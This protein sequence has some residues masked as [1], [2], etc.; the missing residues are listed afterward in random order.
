MT[1]YR[2]EW[3]SGDLCPGGNVQASSTITDGSTSYT[4][5]NLSPG[6][7]CNVSVTASN[8]AGS[9]SSD[10]VTFLLPE[11]GEHTPAETETAL[12][13]SVYCLPLPCIKPCI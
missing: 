10:R 11:S 6:T 12:G 8:S 2:V 5:Q 3:S 13:C 9:S 7:H 1:N 4:I